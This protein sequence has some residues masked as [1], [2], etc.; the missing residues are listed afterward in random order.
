[1]SELKKEEIPQSIYIDS[2]SYSYKETKKNGEYSYR[3]KVRKCGVI[4][5]IDKNN[6]EKIIK[7]EQNT[8]IEYKKVSNKD[9][10]CN[11]WNLN[12]DCEDFED[13]NPIEQLKKD[14]EDYRSGETSYAKICR[15]HDHP[16]EAEVTE[17]RT[18]RIVKILE[19]KLDALLQEKDI[20]KDI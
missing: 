11:S 8:K 12:G 3:C 2:F 1:M 14:I 16:T 18:E 20:Q 15:R 4:I 5:S 13:L 7:G 9:H 19:E 10:I 6:L 17:R